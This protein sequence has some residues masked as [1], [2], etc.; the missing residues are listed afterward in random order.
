MWC[1]FSFTL[2]WAHWV[3]TS[4]NILFERN[5]L[6]ICLKLALKNVRSKE[7]MGGYDIKRWRF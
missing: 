5:E 1:Y 3:H 2:G 7:N 6:S 4:F